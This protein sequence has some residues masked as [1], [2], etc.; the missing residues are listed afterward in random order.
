MHFSTQK[1]VLNRPLD[2]VIQAADSGRQEEILSFVHITAE[3]NKLVLQCTDNKH[4]I[5]VDVPMDVDKTGKT[6]VSARKLASIVGTAQAD[7]AIDF[8]LD[9]DEV[10]I[11]SGRFRTRLK[12]LPAD[13]FPLLSNMEATLSFDIEKEELERM[14]KM[15]EHAMGKNDV[16]FYLNGMALTVENGQLKMVATDGH[17]LCVCPYKGQLSFNEDFERIIPRESV[18]K[19]LSI[20]SVA[21]ETVTVAL[22]KT[23][24]SFQIPGIR[25]TTKIID[26]KMPD[27]N[28]VIPKDNTYQSKV[29]VD[30]FHDALKRSGVLLESNARGIK[31]SFEK[32]HIKLHTGNPAGEELD[33]EVSCTSNMIEDALP[34][35]VNCDY[36]QD[37]MRNIENEQVVINYSGMDK[38]LLLEE[39]VDSDTKARF[40]I[41]PMRL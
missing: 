26:G 9:S 11:K 10:V 32:E 14:V 39:D 6:T 7:A 3:K 37:I 22:Y 35:G 16:R 36:I 28:A 23:H 31:L 12:T 27:V 4:E 13:T 20:L 18:G 34:I 19:L 15:A 29:S 25:L 1:H 33:D 2:L 38:A 41:M 40:V 24:I 21:D 30:G 17:R 8:K 5:S